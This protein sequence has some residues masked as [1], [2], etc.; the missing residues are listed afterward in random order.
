[1]LFDFTNS[2]FIFKVLIFKM[3]K[4]PKIEVIEGSWPTVRLSVTSAFQFCLILVCL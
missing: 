2:A 3:I 4:M 1:M